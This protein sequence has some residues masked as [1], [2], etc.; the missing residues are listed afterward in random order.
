MSLVFARRVLQG[1]APLLLSS[2]SSA[3]P[4]IHMLWRRSFSL[5]NE[6][7]EKL[8]AA[9]GKVS[10]LTTDP[11]NDKKLEL[12]A[13]YKQAVEGPC[14]TPKPGVMDFVGRAKWNAWNSLG[15]LSQSEAAVKYSE[16]VDSLVGSSTSNETA[17]PSNPVKLSSDDLLV[18][19]EGGVQTITLNRPSKK[20]A[21]T[22]KM[23]E[24]ITSLLNSSAS[25]PAIK[26]TVVTGNGDYYCSGNDLSNFMNI[27]PEGPEKLAA[28]SAI[29]L[30][31]FVSSL[32]RYPKPLVAC[33]NGPAVGISVTTLLLFDLVYAA[34]NATFHTPFMQLGQSPEACSSFLYPRIMG[35]AKSNELLILGRKISAEE[36]FERNMITRV[37]PKDELQERVKEIV[38]E[39]SELPHQSVVKSKALIRSSFTDL[40]EDANAKECELLRE[41]WLSEECM[42]AIMKFLEKRK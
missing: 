13:L 18:T 42:Q 7:K 8:E 1:R 28:D 4:S 16:L 23:Y 14:D 25:N 24:D 19:E 39:L 12:Y 2:S 30:R 31:N 29:L 6:D 41:R 35:P 32:I 37:F 5:S 34:D 3:V 11:G 26:A 20:N 33:V 15:Q 22:V 17:S 38:R 21:I 40:L 9:K 36:A 10:Q 27:P